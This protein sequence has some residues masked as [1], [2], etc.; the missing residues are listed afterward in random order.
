MATLPIPEWCQRNG[1]PH[2]WHQS[3][4]DAATEYCSGCGRASQL[5]DGARVP[6]DRPQPCTQQMLNVLWAACRPEDE[7]V[8]MRRLARQAELRRLYQYEV[9]ELGRNMTPVEPGTPGGTTPWP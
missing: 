9:A 2:D 1:R 3:V 6:A 4:M 8:R 5:V 7:R